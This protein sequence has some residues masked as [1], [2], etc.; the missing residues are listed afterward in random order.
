MT[1]DYTD[2]NPSLHYVLCS[3]HH[4]SCARPYA[5]FLSEFDEL[6]QVSDYFYGDASCGV[7]S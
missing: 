5:L 1:E 2:L 7:S 4:S 3:L 6:A